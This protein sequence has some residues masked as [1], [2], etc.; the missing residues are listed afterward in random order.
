MRTLLPDHIIENALSGD[1]GYEDALE[2]LDANPFDLFSLA[3]DI[4][5]D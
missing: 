2:L 1:I 3:N 5:Y 4:R